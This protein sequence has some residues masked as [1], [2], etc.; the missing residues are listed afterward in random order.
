M[1]I[2]TQVSRLTRPLSRTLCTVTK[3]T[4]TSA[5]GRTFNPPPTNIAVENTNPSGTYRPYH[6][7]LSLAGRDSVGIVQSVTAAIESNGANLEGS[8]MALLGGDF[9]MIAHITSSSDDAAD[10]VADQV[11]QV[12]PSFSVSIRTT[13]ARS[14]Q[15]NINGNA[16]WEI[17]LEGPDQP[18]IVAAVTQALATNGANVHELD[19]SVSAAPFAGYEMFVMQ[20]RF[21]ASDHSAEEVVNSMKHVE[22]RFGV[23]VVVSP[24]DIES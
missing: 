22:E 18:G 15:V 5:S 17:R 4:S 10:L 8:K 13:T 1:N 11:R 6:A 24:I 19:T 20:G 7:V 14:E 9:A 23:T 3:A 2:S 21:S 12:L 16:G